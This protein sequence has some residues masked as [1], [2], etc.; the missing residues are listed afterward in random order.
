MHIHLL[1]SS[2]SLNMVV[3]TMPIRHILLLNWCIYFVYIART[4]AHS[5][6]IKNIKTHAVRCSPFKF[7][8]HLLLQHHC[9]YLYLFVFIYF[10]LLLLLLNFYDFSMGSM[11][12]R[13]FY[14][15]VLK[16][17]W[18]TTKDCVIVRMSLCMCV[19]S[20][21]ESNGIKFKIDIHDVSTT[22]L[23]VIQ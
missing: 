7:R 11:C 19:H 4:R 5:I 12:W 18:I 22:L 17:N 15:N 9:I 6:Q 21:F 3:I 20:L 14:E 16:K 10:L 13:E 2:S 23:Y 1:L 8:A